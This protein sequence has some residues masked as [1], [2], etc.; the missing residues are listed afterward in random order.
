VKAFREGRPVTVFRDEW[1]TPLGVAT[2]ARALLDIARSGFIGLLHVGGPERLSR[3]KMG[4]RLVARLHADPSLIVPALRADAP[5]AEPR[6]RDVSL[7]SSRWRQLFPGS[8][9]PAWDDPLL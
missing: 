5:A 6:P 2:A 9:W 4:Q 7:D 8:P 3:L 1:R